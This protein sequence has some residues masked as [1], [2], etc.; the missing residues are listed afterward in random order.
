MARLPVPG[1]DRG[2]W[3]DILNTF[4]S[5][6]HNA[7]GTLKTDGTL[8]SKADDDAVVHL[9]GSE[10]IPGNKDFVGT[11]EHH[12]NAVVDT[13]DPRLTDD[14]PPT[15]HQASHQSGGSDEL[16]G[17][18]D[19]NAR[20]N[21]RKDGLS[22][23]TRRGINFIEGSN[24]AITTTDS[25]ASERVNIT[26]DV[27]NTVESV[28]GETGVVV[29][30]KSDIG[31]GNVD[32][33]SDMDK[34]VSSATQ[35]ELDAKQPLDPTLTALAGVSTA[36]NKLPYFTNTDVAA[37]T[38]LT[39]QA[40]A[41]L[42]DPDAATMRE[43]LL[44]RAQRES[45]SSVTAG[46]YTPQLT[47]EAKI[48]QVSSSSPI[49]VVI[50]N[51]ATVSFPVGTWF[52]VMALGSGQVTID[53]T[54]VTMLNSTTAPASATTLVVP[55]HS[56]ALVRKGATDTWVVTL[57]E[58]ATLIALSK[59]TTS[60]D[61]LIYAT[62]SDTFTTTDL[63]SF[64]RTLLDDTNAAAARTTLEVPKIVAGTSGTGVGTNNKAVTISG[65]TLTAG[66]II[67]LTLTNGNSA[68]APTLNVNGGGAVTIQQTGPAPGF[69]ADTGK[70]WI[71]YYTGSTYVLMN[72][73]DPVDAVY[74]N[75]LT[76]GMENFPRDSITGYAS[77]VS[78]R[79]SLVYFTCDKIFTA[80]QIRSFSG[81]TAASGATTAKM[82]IYLVNSDSTL[83]L[84]AK[85]ANNTSLWSTINTVYTEVLDASVSMVRN[86]RY[87]FACLFDG[88]TP[89]NLVGQSYTNGNILTYTPRLVGDFT[90]QTDIPSSLVA[91]TGVA[92]Q[93]PFGVV[94][95]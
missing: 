54:A 81:T 90:G 52:K 12:G 95:P 86:Q 53:G 61:K 87:A 74:A 88:T 77:L 56:E 23:G 62:G 85:S 26:I 35:T 41:L 78:Q 60:A 69:Q 39:T 80:T 16:A 68:T 73:K 51:N 14:R 40:R 76:S 1:S 48:L 33:T 34:P 46:P 84:L 72:D 65:Y 24:V 18:L 93:R 22:V 8:A 37:T 7:D 59:L 6:E 89:P 82:G 55:R 44:A 94:L 25:P 57:L 13:T 17:D 83:T 29:L 31:L 9:A 79:L 32:N 30:D 58:D 45:I 27:T 5:V 43:T 19:A 64:S 36:A 75:K 92:S 50:P 70:V 42:D 2:K 11:L 71:L 38:D 21:V 67:A 4:L 66:D 91:A 10:V 49:S 15:S 28:N 20:V 3:G 63:S 47:D